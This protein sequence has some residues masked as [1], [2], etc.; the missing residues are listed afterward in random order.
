MRFVGHTQR[1]GIHK[2]NVPVNNLGESGFGMVFRELLK[3]CWSVKAF[4]HP[5]IPGGFNTG[6]KKSC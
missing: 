1:G 4:T 5:I 2:V 3:S 6:Q